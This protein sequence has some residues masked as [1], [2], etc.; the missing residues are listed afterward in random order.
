MEKSKFIVLLCSF[1]F[2]EFKWFWEFVVLLYF[3]KNVDLLRL[4]E[5]LERLVF[6]FIGFKVSKE[7]VF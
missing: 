5:Y 3:N 2:L 6:D 4:I 1:V 7:C